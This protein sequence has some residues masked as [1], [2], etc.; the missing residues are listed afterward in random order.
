MNVNDLKCFRTVYEE[1]SINKAAGRV[2]MT[3]QGLSRIINNLEQELGATLFERTSKGVTAT[4]SARLLYRH[5]ESLIQEFE[6]IQ[7]AMRQ[8]QERD[9]RLKIACARGVLN[10]LS[11][12]FLLQFMESN[13]EIDVS[14]KEDS[15]EEV[16]EAVE[17]HMADVGLVV[18]RTE[19]PEIRE[20]LLASRQVILLVYESHPFFDRSEIGIQELKEEKILLLNE[21]YQI[22][23][24]F[25][26]VCQEAGFEPDVVCKTSDT[27]FLFRLCKQKMG[28]GV[29]MDFSI[30]DF[31]MEGVRAVSLQEAIRWDIYQIFHEDCSGY[32][33]IRAFCQFK[34]EL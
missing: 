17:N 28:L 9:K 30:H 32:R 4:E 24:S 29:L 5:G 25:Y 6:R 7:N 8:L 16:K 14:W 15:N 13:P 10:A 19:L 33:N 2:F 12:Q 18:G 31:N 26:N 34:K 27:H 22:Y 1:Q 11:L 20:E 3:A 23:H 21:Q